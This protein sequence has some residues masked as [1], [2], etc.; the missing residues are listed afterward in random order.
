[1]ANS[2]LHI[3]DGY[4]FE[5]PK[6]LWRVD[7]QSMDEVPAFL[8]KAHPHETLGQFSREMSGK[9][10][11]PQPFGTLK[12]LHDAESGFC[13]SKYMVLETVVALLLVVLFTRFGQKI[14]DG[15]P[16]RGK[17]WNAID[18]LLLYIRDSIARSAIGEHDADHFVPLLW[19]VFFFILVCNLFGMLPWLGAPTGAFGATFALA[20]V[21]FGT[22]L[23]AGMK[24]FGLVG[25]WLNQVP[26]MELPLLLSPL[27]L[28]IFAIEFVGLFIKHAVLAVRLLAN[29]VA[30]HLVLLGIMGIIVAAAEASHG[31]W[32]AATTASVLGSTLFSCLE[33]FVA[34]LQAYVFTFL[35]ALFISA[36]VHHH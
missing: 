18:A 36:A 33:L 3:K 2:V 9:I 4:F 25:F 22:V 31:T 27:K 7:Y 32:L 23:V 10:L 17:F 16:P 24:K 14:K 26:H 13:V 30:G 19:T 35:S 15:E 29:M 6:M 8:R 34:F 1:M 20:C 11:I 28:M 21:M 5:V 12:N